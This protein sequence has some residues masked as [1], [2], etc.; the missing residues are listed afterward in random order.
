L[1]GAENFPEAMIGLNANLSDLAKK[2]ES[3]KSVAEQRVARRVLQALTVRIYEEAFAL[4]QIKSYASI[5]AKLELLT[6]IAPRDPRV[7]YELAVAYARVGNKSKA[8][9]A[10]GRAIERG[11]SDVARIEQNEDFAILRDD[12]AYQKLLAGLKARSSLGPRARRPLTLN[13]I[14]LG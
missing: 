5:P 10:L 2:A 9:T 6:L 12:A 1:P 13:A 7:F 11:F 14:S 8:T 3:S 4:K